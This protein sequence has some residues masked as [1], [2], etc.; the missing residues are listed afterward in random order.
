[1]KDEEVR[2]KEEGMTE[3]ERI[4]EQKKREEEEGRR[5]K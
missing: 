3:G 5:K 2:R 1:M 4:R